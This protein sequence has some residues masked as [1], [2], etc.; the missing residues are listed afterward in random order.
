MNVFCVASSITGYERVTA[1]DVTAIRS[2]QDVM[3]LKDFMR[4]WGDKN[5]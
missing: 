2:I 5:L 1:D 3:Q 4:R